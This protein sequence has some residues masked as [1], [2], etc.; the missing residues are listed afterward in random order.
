MPVWLKFSS[1]L[2]LCV[3]V[4]VYWRYYGP[5]NFLWFSDIALVLTVAAIWLNNPLLA[6]MPALSVLFLEIAWNID[7]ITRL[8]T[9][10]RGLG[11]ADYMFDSRRPL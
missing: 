4:P 8:I 3:L 2:F 9:G 5:A 7:F 6:S 11:L 10:F 1:L